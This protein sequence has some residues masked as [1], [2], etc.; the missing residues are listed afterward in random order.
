MI[1]DEDDQCEHFMERDLVILVCQGGG[2]SRLDQ[3]AERARAWL[4]KQAFGLSSIQCNVLFCSQ[5]P[6]SLSG[7]CHWSSNPTSARALAAWCCCLAGLALAGGASC[8]RS[9]LTP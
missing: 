4:P 2:V 5:I 1:I 6:V 8:L 3:E 7:G 9:E